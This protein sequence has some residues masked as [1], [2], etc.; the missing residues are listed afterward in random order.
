LNVDSS[1]PSE[2]NLAGMIDYLVAGVEADPRFGPVYTQTVATAAIDIWKSLGEGLVKDNALGN[3]VADAIRDISGAQLAI[4]PQGFIAENIYSG[5]VKG[6]EIF[7]AV[8]Y[9]FDQETGLGLKLATFE[10]DGMSIMAGLEFAVYNMPY[11]EEFFL[12][13][14]NLSYAYNLNLDP[15]SRVDYSS[16]MID[17]QPINP[18]GTY[19]I[20]TDDAVIPFISQIPGFNIS[21]L[22]ITDYSLYNVVRDFMTANSPV[23]YYAEGRVIDLALFSEPVVGV[24]A[25]SDVVSL[26]YQNGTISGR[27]AENML[28]VKLKVVRAS[29]QRGQ[30]FPAYCQLQ[31]FK[32]KV[33]NLLRLNSISAFSAG[34]LLYL[35]DKLGETFGLPDDKHKIADPSLP[36]DFKLLQNRPNPFNPE[37]QIAYTIPEGCDASIEIYDLLGR[38]VRTLVDSYQSPGNYSVTW[39]GCDEAGRKVSSGVY[40]YKLRAGDFTQ[41]RKMSLMK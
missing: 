20:V 6:N 33:E 26:F 7:R 19:S 38:R 10:T 16:I 22:Q 8:P 39:N 14:S 35:A 24:D 25:L 27:I 41:T 4:Q 28:Q 13:G 2:P 40:F 32:T 21:N 12:H 29:L 30:L 37:T 9:G 11:V 3:M 18:F 15:G 23:S 34:R 31:A 1:I 5:P 36:N 17:G